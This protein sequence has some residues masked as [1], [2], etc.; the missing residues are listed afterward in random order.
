MIAPL[1]TINDVATYLQIP[2][3]T[4]YSWRSQKK[5]PPSAKVGKYVRY[6][7]DAVQTWLLAQQETAE[8]DAA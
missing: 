7:P 6:D 4:L 5:G 1:W 2:V 3:N 8:P